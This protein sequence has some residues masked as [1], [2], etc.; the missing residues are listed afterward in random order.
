[1]SWTAPEVDRKSAPSVAGERAMLEGWL[2]F[3]RQTLLRKCQDLTGSQLARRE[4]PPST[5]SL[6]G[7]I[8][9]MTEVERGW[10]RRGFAKESVGF[11]YCGPE[12]WDADFNRLDAQSA[13]SDYERYLAEVQEVRS[14]TPGASLDAAFASPFRS[15]QGDI[16]LRWVYLH[17]I[18]EYARHNGHAD[19]L[20]E[21][22]DGGTG[23]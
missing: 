17:M 14:V 12:D 9:H 10:F 15:E 4:I 5:L 6:L 3:Q 16:S 20:R 11:V 2:E 22:I 21:R 1:V 19:L 13:Q 8:R 18:E 23:R 7:L